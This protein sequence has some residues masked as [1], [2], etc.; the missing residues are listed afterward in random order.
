MHKLPPAL[1]PTKQTRS[2]VEP[3]KQDQ[4]LESPEAWLAWIDVHTYYYAHTPKG[5]NTF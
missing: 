3:V 1:S 2:A 5:K 4:H